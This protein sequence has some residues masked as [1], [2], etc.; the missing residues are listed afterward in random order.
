MCRLGMLASPSNKREAIL[1]A[2][3]DLFV[4]KGISA[5]TTRE[6]AG[7]ANTAEGNLYRHFPSKD[8]L[9]RHLFGECAGRFRK[10]LSEAVAE[11]SDPVEHLRGLVRALFR[12]AREEQTAF[13]YLMLSHHREFETGPVRN[14]QPLP[15]DIFT[16][17]IRAGIESGR[18]L[19]VEP[20]LATSWVIGMTQRAIT[21]LQAGKISLPHEEIA[22]RTA[23]AAIRLLTART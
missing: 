10:M 8:H 23:E 5:A 17:T 1:A 21:F 4:E 9:A 14:P 2:A 19:S 16:D 20:D 22:E 11:G 12:F 6:I 3:L 13:A 15:K 7:R 18:F